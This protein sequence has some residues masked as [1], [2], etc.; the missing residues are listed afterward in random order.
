MNIYEVAFDMSKQNVEQQQ[1]TCRS[2]RQL[3]AIDI[4]HV[5]CYKL[6]VAST[7]CWCGRGLSDILLKLEALGYIS[8]AE[9]LGISLTTFTQCTPKAT[10]FG[11]IT[12]NNGH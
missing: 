12:Q 5:E 4:R 2:N 8:V 1:A 7:C 9:S 6:P 3:V 10:E 11:E